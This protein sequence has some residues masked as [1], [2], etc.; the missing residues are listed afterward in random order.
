MLWI[1]KQMTDGKFIV[2]DGIDGCGSTT[3]AQLLFEWLTNQG[4]SAMLTEE[5]SSRKV[6]AVIKELIKTQE[7]TATVDALLFAA[8]RLDHVEKLIIP[9]L[10]KGKVVVS[11]R[12]IESSIAY[13]TA[14]GVEKEWVL[15][16]NKYVRTPDLTIILDITPELGLGRKAMVG[17]KFEEIAFLHKVREIYLQRARA[18]GYPIIE[19]SRAIRDTQLDLQQLIQPIL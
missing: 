11:D 17:D 4:Y 2:L 15:E 6:G 9:A 1:G 14:S 8:D 19:T 5:P 13:Q 16:L 3:H 18:L 12:Y 10:N 7:T